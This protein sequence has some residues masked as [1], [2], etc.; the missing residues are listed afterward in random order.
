VWLPQTET[1]LY[2]QIRLLPP[3]IESHIICETTQH[4]D[5]YALPHIHSA[6]P[7]SRARAIWDRYG[8]RVLGR[9]YPAHVLRAA[10]RVQ[11]QVL[12][13]HFGPVGWAD[14][15]VA[16]CLD[17]PHVVTFYGV[18]ASRVPVERPKWRRRYGQLFAAVTRV[19][20]EGPHMGAALVALGCPPEKIRVHHLGVDLSQLRYRPRQWRAGQPLRVLLAASFREKKGLTYAL[21]ALARLRT[22]AAVEITIIGDAGPE[23]DG[24]REKERIL[25]VIA[26]NGLAPCTRLLGY[27]PHHVLLE[28]ASQ[29]HAFLSPS[30]TAST[31]DTEGGA[32]VTILEMAATGMPVVSTTHCDIPGLFP[33]TAR[34]LLAEE[35]DVGGLVDR[36]RWL[37][38]H[39]DGWP[40]LVEATRK[41]IEQEFDAKVQGERMA[42]LYRE[43]SRL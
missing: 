43:V 10:R 15:G 21:E 27:Q 42:D 33:A 3:G 14:L 11:A 12:H 24:R 26:G 32:P 18:D 9:V 8:R 23:E 38:E 16:R 39:A 30:V 40:A 13:S 19:L 31:G 28:E 22:E 17:L 1:W 2:T 20:C 41:W 7:M 5:Q 29:H 36:L 6:G 34:R 37:M 4:L 25:D 35:R